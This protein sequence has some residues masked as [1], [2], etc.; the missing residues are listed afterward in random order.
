MAVGLTLYLPARSSLLKARAELDRLVPMED[1]YTMLQKKFDT[2]STQVHIYKMLSNINYLFVA[3]TE[4][5]SN[6]ID[7]YIDYIEED[8]STL[9]IPAYP[10]LP[11]SLE[12]QF[13]KVTA[14][15]VSDPEKALDELQ[16]F[17]NDLLLL[18]DNLE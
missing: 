18:I 17:H 5:E 1:E 12:S 6:R 15:A 14:K 16:K 10:D 8:L 11:T 4:K 13:K 7:Q 9:S 3:L 2:L